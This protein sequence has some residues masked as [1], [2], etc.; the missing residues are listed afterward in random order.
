MVCVLGPDLVLLIKAAGIFPIDGEEHLFCCPKWAFYL[1]DGA[2]DDFLSS[3]WPPNAASEEITA[4]IT[5]HLYSIVRVH[6]SG[7]PVHSAKLP[8]IFFFLLLHSKKAKR[9]VDH[10]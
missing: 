5:T 7:E 2:W 10:V 3:H 8:A 6:A 1:D 9:I 4:R